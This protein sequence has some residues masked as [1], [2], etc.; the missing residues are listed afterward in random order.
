MFIFGFRMNQNEHRETETSLISWNLSYIF[1]KFDIQV[2][3]GLGW[4]PLNFWQK[5]GQRRP[6]LQKCHP[7]IFTTKTGRVLYIGVLYKKTANG[8]VWIHSSPVCKTGDQ[9][10]II[11][12]S[13]PALLYYNMKKIAQKIIWGV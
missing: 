11:V 8:R 7:R 13:N 3:I 2:K 5:L 4:H 1:W 6:L 12:L 9:V 10:A